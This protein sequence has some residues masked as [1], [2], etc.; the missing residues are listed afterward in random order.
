MYFM[1]TL[2]TYFYFLLFLGMEEIK[3][4]LFTDHIITYIENSSESTK[5]KPLMIKFSKIV[6]CKTNIQK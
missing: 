6:A 2:M 1:A 5:K 3:L 4:S